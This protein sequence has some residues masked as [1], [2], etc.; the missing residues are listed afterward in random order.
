M[1]HR[2]DVVVAERVEDVGVCAGVWEVEVRGVC[3]G[4][5]RMHRLRHQRDN[6]RGGG[7]AVRHEVSIVPHDVAQQEHGVRLRHGR[8]RRRQ[9]RLEQRPRAVAAKGAVRVGR[10]RGAS[11]RVLDKGAAAVVQRIEVHIGQHHNVSDVRR[12]GRRHPARRAA[13]ALAWCC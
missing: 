4:K 6:V 1:S 11:S 8:R 5:G 3:H 9:R 12:L 13:G 10:W 7:R 2:L